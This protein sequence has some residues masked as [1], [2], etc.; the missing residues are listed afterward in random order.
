M[1]TKNNKQPTEL[2]I[3]TALFELIDMHLMRVEE[4]R[5]NSLQI[6]QK[7]ALELMIL[8]NLSVDDGWRLD[9]DNRKYV[10]ITT[11]SPNNEDGNT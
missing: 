8:Q 4:H 5:Q 7:A 9:I 6:I 3:P 2:P 1:S 11:T 10:K